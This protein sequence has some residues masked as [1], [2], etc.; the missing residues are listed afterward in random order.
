M[1]MFHLQD[2]HDIKIMVF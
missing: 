1:T 2:T